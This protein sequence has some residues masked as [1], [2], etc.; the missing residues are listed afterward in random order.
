MGK[1]I[2]KPWGVYRDMN[3]SVYGIGKIVTEQEGGGLRMRYSEQ[4]QYEPQLWDP[5]YVERFHKLE[6]ATEYYNEKRPKS[7]AQG[8]SASTDEEIRAEVRRD[9]PSYFQK[10]N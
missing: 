4:Q 5:S 6:L 8:E 9:F 10:K 3:F 2:E 7:F 1:E